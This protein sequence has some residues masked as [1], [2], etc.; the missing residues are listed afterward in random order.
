MLL[1]WKET[2]ITELKLNYSLINLA[3][4]VTDLE[5]KIIRLNNSIKKNPIER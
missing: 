1:F 5:E 2:E 4:K 3:N